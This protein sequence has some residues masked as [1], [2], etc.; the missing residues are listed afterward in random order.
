ME[1]PAFLIVVDWLM[2]AYFFA[3]NSTYLMLM[4][5]ATPELIRQRRRE[6]VNG[7]DDQFANP[8]APGVSLIVAAYNEEAGIVPSVRS[9]LELH[10][11]DFEVVVVDDGSKDQTFERLREAFELIEV[12]RVVNDHVPVMGEVLSTHVAAKGEPLVVVRKSNVGRRADASNVGINAASKELVCIVDA[13]CVMSK[14]GLLRVARPFQDDPLRVVATGGV[15]RVANG[16][17][18]EAGELIEARM[19]KGWLERIQVVEYLRAFFLG[20]VGW[21]RLGSLLVIS[22]AFG[23]FRRDLIIELGGFDGECIG[24]DAEM[25]ARIHHHQR[26]NKRDYRVVF[27]PDP[28]SWTEVPSTF[29]VLGRQRKRWSRGLVEVLLRHKTMMGN[30]RY[31]RAGLLMFPYYLFFE[32]IGPIIELFGIGYVL[33]ALIFGWINVPFALLFLAVALLYGI[34]L[35]L[36]AIALE[37]AYQNAYKRWSDIWIAA[38]CAVVENIGFR[39][40]HSWWRLRGVFSA[41]FATDSSWGTMTRKG[42]NSEADAVEP[43]ASRA[44]QEISE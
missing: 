16:C 43:Q 40:L 36:V 19:P 32:A 5:L 41:L 9:M 18:I 1:Q 39:Q 33:V 23:M 11:P 31:G 2:L 44:A 30:P 4:V 35:S 38:A 17:Q 10:Y 28:V 6:D 22:G 3:I 12:P 37:D 21:S 27:V 8:F 42:L 15:I 24:E 34:F 20:R 7:L 29:A 13:D 26:K 14:D 25:V